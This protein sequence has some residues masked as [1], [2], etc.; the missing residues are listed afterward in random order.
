M[1]FLH[2]FIKNYDKDHYKRY[3]KAK[4]VVRVF[5]AVSVVVIILLIIRAIRMIG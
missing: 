3:P 2:D 4:I 1:S 5:Y